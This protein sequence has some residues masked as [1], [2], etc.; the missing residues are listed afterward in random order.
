VEKERISAQIDDQ[1]PIDKIKIFTFGSNLAGRHGK[2][3]ALY[4]RQHYGAVYGIGYG[5]TGNA[6]AIP[7]KDENLQTLPLDTIQQFVHRFLA[8]ATAHSDLIFFVTRI[9]CGLAGYID[10][11]IAPMFAHAPSNCILPE[12]WRDFPHSSPSER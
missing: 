11:Q 9:G 8:Y 3:A 6:F 2:G 7:T 5:R 12:G 1:K 10:A 4:A